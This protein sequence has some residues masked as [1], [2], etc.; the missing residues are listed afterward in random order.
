MILK[1][2]KTASLEFDRLRV[3]IIQDSEFRKLL[4]ARIKTAKIN[5]LKQALEEYGFKLTRR[6]IR[7]FF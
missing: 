2:N 4:G 3:K 5:A 7:K 1:H 6:D